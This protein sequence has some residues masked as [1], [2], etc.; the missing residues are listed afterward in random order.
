MRYI[1][2]SGPG[3]GTAPTSGQFYNGIDDGGTYYIAWLHQTDYDGR[4]QSAFWMQTLAPLLNASG[5][6]VRLRA[7]K[8]NDPNNWVIIEVDG[9]SPSQ[10]SISTIGSLTTYMMRGRYWNSYGG[11]AGTFTDSQ[12]AFGANASGLASG[13]IVRLTVEHGVALPKAG[14]V[15]QALAKSSSNDFDVA[16]TTLV[17]TGGTTGQ[18][19]VKSSSSNF[20]TTWSSGFPV[21]AKHPLP[22]SSTSYW[23]IPGIWSN[24]AYTTK[25]MAANTLYYQPVI[26]N[27]PVTCN[28]VG[29][30]VSTLSTGSIRIGIYNADTAWQPTTLALD[31]G[32]VSVT[33][34]GWKSITGLTTVLTPGIYLFCYVSDGTPVVSNLIGQP[35]TG[36]YF[37]TALPTNWVKDL[38]VS[39]TYGVLP[40][41]GTAW[42]TVQNNSGGPNDNVIRM[43]W[44]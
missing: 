39:F 10:G 8:E 43:L 12:L 3:N 35:W 17:P 29:L 9:L 40:S 32:T 34:T 24:A 19:L 42:N 18:A 2:N 38:R 33:S 5:Q 7:T 37:D 31:A 27:G 26:L 16:W 28:G 6:T 20:A 11:S 4:D 13:D 23:G 30:N 15:G 14:T 44:S 1:W 25:T 21:M 41:T 36:H 22:K